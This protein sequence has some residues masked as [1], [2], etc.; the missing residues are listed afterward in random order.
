MDEDRLRNLL[1]DF[2]DATGIV[3]P[4]SV[5]EE[6]AVFVK[7]MDVSFE[8]HEGDSDHFHIHFRFGAIMAGRALRVFRLM[9]EANLLVYAQDNGRFA[10]DPDSSE[11]VLMLRASFGPDTTGKWLSETLLHYAEH[12]MYWRNNILH[13][14]DER[15][16]GIASRD[17]QWICA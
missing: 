12:G 17:Y 5:V 4:N 7:G 9:L 14:E 15:F 8:T 1:R 13:G 10:L 3:N 11:S 2:C 6:R 16:N